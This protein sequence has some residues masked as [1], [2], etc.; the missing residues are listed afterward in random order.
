MD[1]WMVG[2]MDGWMED[3]WMKI[4]IESKCFLPSQSSSSRYKQK[5]IFYRRKRPPLEE[6]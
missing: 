2:W 1:G 5:H 3:G 4:M 6:F